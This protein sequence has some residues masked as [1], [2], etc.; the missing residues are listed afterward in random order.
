VHQ[1]LNS[2]NVHISMYILK[3]FYI[4]CEMAVVKKTMHL[5]V[6]GKYVKMLI[7]MCYRYIPNL[8]LSNYVIL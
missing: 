6:Q 7:L 2:G 4:Q 5:Q 1:N 8:K 3:H